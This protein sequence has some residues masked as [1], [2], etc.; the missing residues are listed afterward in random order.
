MVTFEPGELGEEIKPSSAVSSPYILPSSLPRYI[1]RVYDK[2][3]PGNTQL[4]SSSSTPSAST[5]PNPKA[6]NAENKA[7]KPQLKSGATSAASPS[8]PLLT[9]PAAAPLRDSPSPVAPVILPKID[10]HP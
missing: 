8:K 4:F 3:I 5:S 10:L 7:D 2:I 1:K 9:S 6:E